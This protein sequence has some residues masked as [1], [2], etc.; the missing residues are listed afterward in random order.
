MLLTLLLLVA[1]AVLLPTVTIQAQVKT[2]GWLGF[3]L[4]PMGKRSTNRI[5]LFT[6]CLPWPF[7]HLAKLPKGLEK[8]LDSKALCLANGIRST[9]ALSLL[10]VWWGFGELAKVLAGSD[11]RLFACLIALTC[12]L[13]AI[14]IWAKR[15]NFTVHILVPISV[16][17]M[18]GLT[19][20]LTYVVNAYLGAT[21]QTPSILPV[22]F[23]VLFWLGVVILVWITMAGLVPLPHTRGFVVWDATLER[24]WGITGSRLVMVVSFLAPATSLSI[25]VGNAVYTLLNR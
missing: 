16:V 22:W 14:F 11:S 5:W 3:P 8:D 9:A 1:E 19:L 12:M 15:V 24:W 4:I 20:T 17:A 2:L 6:H 13:T 10:L 7:G 21:P 23:N 18:V 25:V